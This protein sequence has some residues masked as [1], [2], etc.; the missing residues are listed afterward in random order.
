MEA[1]LKRLGDIF[2][3]MVHNSSTFGES[4]KN[5]RLGRE[6]F[7]L[8][9]S[10]P[11]ILPGEYETPRDKA[12]LLGQMLEQMDETATP[13]LCMEIRNEIERLD[14]GDVDNLSGLTRLRDYIDLSLPMEEYCARYGVHLE[15]DPV[16]RTGLYEAVIADVEA[17]VAE[18]LHDVPRGMGFCFAYW[19]EK[20]R[21]LG[22]RGIQWLSPALVNPNVMFD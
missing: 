12:C 4:W 20:Q 19:G 13:R 10:L 9:K 8:M 11:D 5:I 6:A 2:R 3:Q 18:A 17:E 1:K 16:E 14:T 22:R 7:A 21:A 15:F